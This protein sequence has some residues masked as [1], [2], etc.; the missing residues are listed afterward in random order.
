MKY[1]SNG[2]PGML[3]WNPETKKILCKFVD[4]EFETEDKKEIK[5]LD[6]VAATKKK[7][8]SGKLVQPRIRRA[9]G[10]E[11]KASKLDHA[12]TAPEDMSVKQLTEYAKEKGIDL[13]KKAK[14]KTAIL[15]IVT[16][17]MAD[18]SGDDAD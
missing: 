18:D 3:I 12:P 2:N 16:E 4:G 7:D 14:G 15:E 1:L 9:D 11:A 5:I 6:V 8:A 17:A 10:S 13:P